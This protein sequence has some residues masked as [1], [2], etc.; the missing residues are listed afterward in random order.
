MA[1][2]DWVYGL[3][4]PQDDDGNYIQALG[5]I[6]PWQIAEDGKTV[7]NLVTGNTYDLTAIGSGGSTDDTRVDVANSS[8]VVVGDASQATFTAS[9][10][11]SVSVTNPNSGEAQVDY[12]VDLPSVSDDGTVVVDPPS[13]IDATTYLSVADDGD[14]TVS[15]AF[16]ELSHLVDY[17]NYDPPALMMADTDVVDNPVRV[18]DGS[19]LEVYRWGAYLLA[20]GTAPAGLQVQL[21]DGGDTVQASANT[22]NQQDASN[23]VASYA[24]SSGSVS[25]FKLRTENAT[26]TDYTTD[27]IGTEWAYRVVA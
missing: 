24:N 26:G 1:Y 11:A 21:L 22:P 6:G 13:D 8:G 16:D 27:G 25:V 18:P 15:V 20:D 7:T 14:G 10:D 17:P 12:S 5:G 2:G 9:Q 3:F 4:P 19:T 23:P